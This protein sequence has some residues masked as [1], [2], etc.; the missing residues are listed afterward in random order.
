MDD[1]DAAKTEVK[2]WTKNPTY[3]EHHELPV[4]TK[5]FKLVIEF[6]DYDSVGGDDDEMGIA[7]MELE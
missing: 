6:F 7:S 2:K 3:N 5:S 4:R 1:E